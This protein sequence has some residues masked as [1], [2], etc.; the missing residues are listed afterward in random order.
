MANGADTV[1]YKICRD[2]EW[3]EALASGV[4]A[5]SSDDARDGY[6]HLSTA[7]QLPGTAAKYFKGQSDLVIVAYAVEALEPLLRWE[8][9]RGGALFPHV[10]GTLAPKE[11]LWVRELPLGPDGVPLTPEDL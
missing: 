9:A 8:P 5:G 3:R 4:Y 7:E 2:V 1:V 6:I 11:A 10:Y